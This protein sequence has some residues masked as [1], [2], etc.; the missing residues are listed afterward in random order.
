[1]ALQQLRDRAHQLGFEPVLALGPRYECAAPEDC[2]LAAI[3]P[4]ARGGLLLLSGRR[5]FDRLLEE[6]PSP[7][8]AD[9]PLDRL[10][11]RLVG[12][13][14][15]EARAA[16]LRA[17]ARFPFLTDGRP[18]AF[19]R[20]GETAGLGPPSLLGLQLHPAHGSWIAY[21]A[22]LLFDRTPAEEPALAA[23]NPCIDCAAPCL[24]ACPAG[25]VARS[26][27]DSAACFDLRLAADPCGDGCRARLA[28]PVGAAAIHP[29][30][31]RRF[32]QEASLR[33]VRRFREGTAAGNRR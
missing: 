7:D 26:G 2:R 6:D 14:L 17:E 1:M 24:P 11:V 8:P 3:A 19:Q 12:S 30:R 27:F 16:G 22:L 33:S 28:C 21:R 31:Q 4:W 18:L 25:A 29:L 9:D 23:A 32:H 13:L 10:T 20:I 15:D 5:L